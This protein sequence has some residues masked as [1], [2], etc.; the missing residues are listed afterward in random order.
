MFETT[1]PQGPDKVQGQEPIVEMNLGIISR[2]HNT[3]VG[4]VTHLKANR[5]TD[6]EKR[7][8]EFDKDRRFEQLLEALKKLASRSSDG[9]T[10]KPKK[11]SGLMDLMKW[12]GRVFGLAFTGFKMFFGK[13]MN[14]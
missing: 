13:F 2:I 5:I 4:I 12:V 8:L 11:S 3:L 14:E 6:S 10:A 1:K 7:E 9:G